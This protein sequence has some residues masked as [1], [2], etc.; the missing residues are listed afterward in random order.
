MKEE[1]KRVLQ[2]ALS[3]AVVDDS[4]EENKHSV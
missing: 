4:R 1:I 2:R 3:G